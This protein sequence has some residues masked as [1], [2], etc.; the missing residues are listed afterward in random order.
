MANSVL[1]QEDIARMELT[2]EDQAEIARLVK[3]GFTEGKLSCDGRNILW[4]LAV[5]V[6]RD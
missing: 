5:T 3:D 2:D 1:G 4:R 6:W